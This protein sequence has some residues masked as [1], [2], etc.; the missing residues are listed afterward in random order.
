MM[1]VTCAGALGNLPR[2]SE[3]EGNYWTSEFSTLQLCA[4]HC[5]LACLLCSTMYY[6]GVIFCLSL[7]NLTSSF[8]TYTLLL[9]HHCPLY[10]ATNIW[11]QL[12]RLFSFKHLVSFRGSFECVLP[13]LKS[14]PLYPL[15]A[16]CCCRGCLT[17]LNLSLLLLVPRHKR[18]VSGTVAELLL[19]HSRKNQ[20]MY[21]SEV[22]QLTKGKSC[23]Q[24]WRRHRVMVLKFLQYLTRCQPKR[25]C[26]QEQR[27]RE[28]QNKTS[29]KSGSTRRASRIVALCNNTLTREEY[30]SR[31]IV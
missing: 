20:P 30:G 31:C 25:L 6:Q 15:F 2:A 21:R 1:A 27:K 19:T 12:T 10:Q 18:E 24:N 8:P 11:V 3:L 29:S 7:Y 22:R 28:L 5:T 17:K 23:S 16:S 26:L 14:P 4:L 9:R 13:A